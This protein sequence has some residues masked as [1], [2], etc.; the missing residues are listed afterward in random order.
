MPGSPLATV[1]HACAADQAAVAHALAASPLLRTIPLDPTRIYLQRATRGEALED[2]VASVPCAVAVARG[3]VDVLSVAVDGREV[4]L[5]SLTVGE[6]F[7]VCNLFAAHDLPTLLRSRDDTLLVRIP[8]EFLTTAIADDPAVN[9]RYLELCNEKIQFLIGR[10]EELTMQTTRSK[11]LDY[12]VL[13]ADAQGVVHL[14]E[15]REELAAY[16]GV[17]RA[18]LFR[19]IAALKREGAIDATGHDLRVLS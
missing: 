1:A 14:P 6:A 3:T 12:L 9:R 7:G 16:L 11:L 5:S 10:I 13:H 2:R 15:S 19:E 8:K 4:R 18:A 17:S